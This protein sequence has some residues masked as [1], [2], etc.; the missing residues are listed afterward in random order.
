MSLG[1]TD[2]FLASVGAGL[3]P[4]HSP[5]RKF[6][7]NLDMSSGVEATIWTQGG[8]YVYPS[9]SGEAMEV[10]SSSASD[11]GTVEIQGL[12]ASFNEVSQ[13]ITLTGITAVPLQISLSRVL[14]AF[15][16]NSTDF[17][18]NIS[19]QGTGGGTVFGHITAD[20]QQTGMAIYTVPAGK[21]GLL[22][23]GCASINRTVVSAAAV[24]FSI[25]TRV[26]GKVFRKQLHLGLQTAGTSV[27]HD[28]FV[29]PSRMPEKTD[30][31][32]NG[33]STAN[34]MHASAWFY[35]LLLSNSEFDLGGLI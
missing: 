21:T 4:G 24:D 7:H 10:V 32:V 12:D 28:D 33:I 8:L 26:F 30:I 17:V 13:I 27:A 1:V 14:R 23:R 3:V 19:I 2:S 31:I 34:G 6:G 5:V 29:I 16:N 11:T 9:D 25:N 35:I 20:E 15:N 18:G 22:M